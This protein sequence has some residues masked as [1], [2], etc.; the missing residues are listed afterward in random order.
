[1]SE[2]RYQVAT[3][4]AGCF[5]GVEAAFRKVPGVVDTE[6]GYCGGHVPHPTYE[7][8][9]TDTTGHA[10]AVRVVFDPEKVSYEQL[11]EVFWSI[12][13]PTTP[14]RQGPDV[15]TQYRSAIF[16]HSEE[17]LELALRSKEECE[18]SGRFGSPIVTEILPAP[19]FYRA[20]E[21]H[22]R[23]LEKRGRFTCH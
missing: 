8:V 22:Q 20:E 2:D 5:W 4:A 7:Q 14:N 10:E 6:V 1:M 11:L 12:H 19:P 13:D 9:C 15:G 3:F 16:C 23:Y 17:Q 21:Y 18:R